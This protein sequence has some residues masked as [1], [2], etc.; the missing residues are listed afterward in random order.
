MQIR[1]YTFLFISL[2]SF[3]SHADDWDKKLNIGIG[4]YSMTLAYTDP[5]VIDDEF[6][7][8]GLTVSYAST[9]HFLIRGT[10]YSLS[11][12]IISELDVSGADVTANFGR[13]LSSEGFKAYFGAG[14]FN[15]TWSIFGFDESFSGI[16]LNGGIGY[17]WENVSLDLTLGL[18]ETSDYDQLT[19]FDMT[20]VST[21][22]LLTARF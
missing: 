9:D 13:G 2:L 11:H 19:F 3:S 21:S 17:N 6:S 16:Q 15:E 5:F 14:F 12:D 10:Y 22:L 1:I 4:T 7:G 18:R 8:T 20:A